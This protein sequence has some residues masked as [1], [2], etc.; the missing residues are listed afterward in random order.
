MKKSKSS[1]AG[2]TLIELM[3]VIVIVAILATITIPSYQEYVRRANASQAQDQLQQIAILLDKHKSR[4]F[5]YLDF[6]LA[7]N[8]TTLPQNAVGSAIK[9]NFTVNTG[10]GQSWVITAQSQD[11][12]NFSFLMSSSGVRCKNK[13]WTN[14][15]ASTVTCGTAGREEW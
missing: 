12:R 8:L 2:F 3:V 14:I 13:T 9:Y 1:Y 15:N 10:N 11:S 4:N 7:S 5:N 6:V